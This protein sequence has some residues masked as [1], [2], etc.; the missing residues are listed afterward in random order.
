MASDWIYVYYLYEGDLYEDGPDIQKA[1]RQTQ[2]Q[3]PEFKMDEHYLRT[4]F[5]SV[6]IGASDMHEIPGM[7]PIENHTYETD[8]KTW[9][10]S[11][12]PAMVYALEAG[13]NLIGGPDHP[14]G[15]AEGE[16]VEQFAQ[17]VATGYEATDQ[18]PLAAY[19]ETPLHATAIGATG[20]PPATAESLAHD[21][22]EHLSWVTVF[23]PEMVDTY[24][25]ETLLT[26]PAWKTMELD[27]GAILLVAHEDPH[28]V[29][30][31]KLPR[32]ADHIGLKSYA[33]P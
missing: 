4:V 3:R 10:L 7:D 27:D 2:A 6:S 9:D 25:R 20:N 15:A 16:P 30:P 8:E 28:E 24:G 11:E 23:P 33:D 14:E 21:E 26:A 18:T 32:V 29:E 19:A 5:G 12:S 1:H 22:Y 17:M 13:H 31:E